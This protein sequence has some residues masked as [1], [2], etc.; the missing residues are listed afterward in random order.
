MSRTKKKKKKSLTAITYRRKVHQTPRNRRHVRPSDLQAQIVERRRAGKH[1]AALFG[2]LMRAPYGGVVP[3]HHAIIHDEQRR[4]RVRNGQIIL[5][6]GLQRRLADLEVGHLHA[7]ETYAVVDRHAG[8]AAGKLR[9][10][11]GAESVGSRRV[12]L[13]VGHEHGHRERR[14]DVVEKGLDGRGRDGVELRKGQTDQAVVARVLD[15]LLAHGRGQLDGLRGDGGA[16]NVDRVG[17]LGARGAGLVAELDVEGGALHGLEGGRLGA[18]EE[19]VAGG[20][21]GGH[22]GVEDPAA[23]GKGERVSKGLSEGG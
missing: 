13:E 18:V 4:P 14:R 5:R 7:P 12:V 10:V 17:A 11:D 16:A 9:L 21:A 6:V 19:L 8:Q 23:G 15:E 3:I 1:D 2:V 22:A 20:L